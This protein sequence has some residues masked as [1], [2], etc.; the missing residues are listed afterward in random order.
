MNSNNA[1][2]EDTR[3]AVRRRRPVWP[4]R[5]FPLAGMMA[6]AVVGLAACSGGSPS[7][8]AASGGP[9]GSSAEALKF[10][11]CMRAH[12]IAGYP[13]P[14]PAPGGGYSI[15]VRSSPGSDL[16]R[17]SPQFQAAQDACKKYTPFGNLTAAQKVAANAKALKYSQCMRSHGITSYPDPN[18]QGT[19][20]VDASRGIDPTSPQFENAQ[21]ACQRLDN[22]FS[23][24]T[25]GFPS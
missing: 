8:S 3:G 18:G 12:G 6:A 16:N 14:V 5:T 20:V 19:I 21:K 22:G 9:S 4:H 1:A 24:E 2:P 11:Q 23:M 10:S 15:H 25:S 17:H 13:D 7:P